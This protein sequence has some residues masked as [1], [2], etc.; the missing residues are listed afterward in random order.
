MG[1]PVPSNRVARGGQDPLSLELALAKRSQGS[2]IEVETEQSRL[3]PMRV[4]CSMPQWVR[5]SMKIGS[6]VKAHRDRNYKTLATEV[7]GPKG[8]VV[9]ARERASGEGGRFIH[10]ERTHGRSTS[11][12]HRAGQAPG[13]HRDWRWRH[14]VVPDDKPRVR[15]ATPRRPRSGVRREVPCTQSMLCIMYL[16]IPQLQAY[17]YFSTYHNVPQR[18][19]GT[20]G[21]SYEILRR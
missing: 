17:R 10:H 14:S 13:A 2:I 19:A 16:P 1:D 20:M 7:T 8:L 21:P 15:R 18:Q 9:T 12:M 6:C 5:C 4:C 11:W 3:A